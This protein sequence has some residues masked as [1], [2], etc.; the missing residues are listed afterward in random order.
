METFNIQSNNVHHLQGEHLFFSK[1]IP[2]NLVVEL[3]QLLSPESK[4][5]SQVGFGFTKEMEARLLEIKSDWSE[6]VDPYF[7]LFKFYFRAANY[8]QAEITVWQVAKL[9]ANRQGFSLNYRLLS[10]ETTDWL[11][12][13]SDQRH[14]LF[15]L[16]ALGV[17]RLRRNRVFLA[18]K[19]L[20]KLLELDPFDEIGG[21]NF[22]DIANAFD[23]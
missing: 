8:R 9:L 11:A 19:V 17:I 15:C 16:K 21:G 1:D 5:P 6:Y 4:R 10:P 14:F 23:D 7:A 12:N 20:T 22:L 13:D 3:S 18:K 2:A